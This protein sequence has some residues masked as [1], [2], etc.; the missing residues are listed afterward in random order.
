MKKVPKLCC[1][2]LVVFSVVFAGC[3]SAP[4]GTPAQT[5]GTKDPKSGGTTGKTGIAPLTGEKMKTA[6]DRPAVMAMINNHPAARP[7]SGL[8]RADIVFEVLAEGEITRFAAFYHGEQKGTIG[9]IR[10][11]RP[12]FLDLAEG[13]DSVVVH[14][15]GSPEAEARFTEPGYPSL[16]E[17]SRNGKYFWR[18]DD[19][20]APHNLYTS[21]EEV[22]QGIAANGFTD[23]RTLPQLSFAAEAVETAAG[24]KVSE[25]AHHIRVVYSSLYELGYSYDADAKRYTRDTMGE[26]QVDRESGEVLAMQNVLVIKAKHRVLDNKGRRAVELTGSGQGWLFQ[27]GGVRDIEWKYADGFPRPFADG[28]ELPLVPGKTWVNVIPEDATVTY[29]E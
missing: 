7:Q 25:K 10:S 17:I 23:R 2:I 28:Q 21:L 27:G 14:A 9:P 4:T 8:G 11:V 16:N 22:A 29:E 24:G 3:T 5:D 20:E 26:K 13:L 1:L 6:T 15:G 18:A 12:Y 19:R